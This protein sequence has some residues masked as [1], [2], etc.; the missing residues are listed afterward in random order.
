[1]ASSGRSPS[2]YISTCSSLRGKRS[3]TLSS[4]CSR[5]A[6]GAAVHGRLA[7]AQGSVLGPLRRGGLGEAYSSSLQREPQPIHGPGSATFEANH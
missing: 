7:V 5:G 3:F 6:A 4:P 1:M 2:R